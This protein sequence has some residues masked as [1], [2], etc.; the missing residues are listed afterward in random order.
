MYKQPRDPFEARVYTP[1]YR[2]YGMIYLVP[3]GATADLLNQE[4]RLLLPMT[5]VLVYTP[6]FKHPPDASELKATTGF[7]AVPKRRILWVVGGRPATP[8]TTGAML[9]RQSL[10]LLYE[11][12]AIA[13]KL[14]MPQHVRLSDY[15]S[16]AKPF[17]TLHEARL[18]VLQ[19]DRPIVELEPE[20]SFEFVTV[21][22]HRIAGLIE[23]PEYSGET[24]RLTLV[25]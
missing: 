7:L 18:Y 13:G 14:D 8:R 24:P 12:Y 5:G 4:N 3:K 22:L 11:G 20:E 17:Q 23:S 21:N 25:T 6:G 19:P 1:E 16:T 15:L 9:R 2:V 10:V